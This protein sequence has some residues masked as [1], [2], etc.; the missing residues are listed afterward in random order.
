MLCTVQAP[1]EKAFTE[2]SDSFA[3]TVPEPWNPSMVHKPGDPHYDV[4]PTL[5][6]SLHAEVFVGG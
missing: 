5:V 6:I 1:G 3:H 4:S 2:Q